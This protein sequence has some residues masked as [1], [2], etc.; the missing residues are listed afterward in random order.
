[1]NGEDKGFC[2]KIVRAGHLHGTS[3]G[4][5]GTILDCLKFRNRG[6][7]ALGNQMGEA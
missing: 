6:G 7:E 4:A 1:M 3:S 5:E 2:V